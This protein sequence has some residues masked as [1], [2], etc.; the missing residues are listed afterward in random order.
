MHGQPQRD[1][2]CD[3][4]PIALG[5]AVGFHSRAVF[6]ALLVPSLHSMMMSIHSCL[7]LPRLAFLVYFF[8]VTIAITAFPRI[9]SCT[10]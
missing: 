4:G 1:C 7:F 2:C 8:K 10:L 3:T 6:L 5:W 9:D